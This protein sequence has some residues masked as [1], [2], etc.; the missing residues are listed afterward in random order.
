MIVKSAVKVRRSKGAVPRR[1][2][3]IMARTSF[4]PLLLLTP[5]EQRTKYGIRNEN[6]TTGIVRGLERRLIS[7]S[8]PSVVG[9]QLTELMAK[10]TK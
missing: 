7:Y 2:D 5:D 6:R 9:G 10:M 1:L 8:S 3:R 4:V